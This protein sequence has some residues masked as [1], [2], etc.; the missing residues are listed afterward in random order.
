[1]ARAKAALQ[2]VGLADRGHHQPNQLSGG[3]RQRVAVARAIVLEPA[4][5]LADEPTGNLD[6]RTG[7]EILALF[8]ELNDSGRTIVIVT[9]D[10]DVSAFCK[11]QI[12]MRDGK[13]V[14]ER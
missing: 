8:K 6:S 2:T 4:I 14:A 3:Q 10:P 9:H 13:V 11:R 7:K 1:K 5:L 12:T